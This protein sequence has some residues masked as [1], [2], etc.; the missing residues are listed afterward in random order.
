MHTRL[1]F[2][3]AAGSCL[4]WVGLLAHSSHSDGLP[5]WAFLG[6]SMFWPN[7][8]PCCMKAS[9]WAFML[10]IILV[11]C[12]AS[13]SLL[14][15]LILTFKQQDIDEWTQTKIGMS[16]VDSNKNR[17]VIVGKVFVGNFF[18]LLA[19]PMALCLRPTH[20]ACRFSPKFTMIRSLLGLKQKPFSYWLAFKQQNIGNFFQLLAR[21]VG[22]CWFGIIGFWRN[23]ILGSTIFLC[24]VTG[25][26][27]MMVWNGL[28]LVFMALLMT[29]FAESCGQSCNL[30]I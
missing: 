18:Q 16:W 19:R 23:W 12:C 27:W 25:R 30:F 14:D 24:L 26:G 21:L 29:C 8:C 1:M 28:G 13:I 10:A 3:L 9:W 11:I 7:C 15:W 6:S 2:H 22:F 5:Q 4:K 17:N 20:W